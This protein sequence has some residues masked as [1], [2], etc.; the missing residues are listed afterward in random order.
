MRTRLIGIVILISGAALLLAGVFVTYQQLNFLGRSSEATAIVVD[1]YWEEEY[2]SGDDGP[3]GFVMIGYP[4]FQFVDSR[5]GEQITARGSFGSSSPPYTIGQEVNILYDPE[6][7]TTRVSVNS[8]WDLWL[9]PIVILL[10]GAA[11]TTVGL[12]VIRKTA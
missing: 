12:L 9:L 10:I 7:P 1:L 3:G 5:T 4:V 2:E 11:W 6:N 8:F